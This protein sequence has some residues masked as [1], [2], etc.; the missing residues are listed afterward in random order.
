LGS[1]SP[2]NT[3][4]RILDAAEEL[5]AEQGTAAT[6]LRSLTRLAGVNLAA[7]HYHF[8]PKEALLDA[9]VDRRAGPINRARLLELARLE[10]TGG[11]DG[12]SMEELL[13][14]F[15]LPGLRSLRDLA[16][17][18]DTLTRLM[19]R[20]EGQ[21]AAEVEALYRRHF[22]EVSERFVAALCRALPHLPPRQ[23]AER[24]RFA[25]GILT[26]L[27]SGNLDLD[28]IPGH[29]PCTASDEERT[30]HALAFIVA[31]FRAPA[32]PEES[33]S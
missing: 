24:F 25:V 17:R 12:P 29:P 8:G 4:E 19:A 18:R 16:H 21:P 31:G 30:G 28:V 5:F 9:V 20:V 27:F 26:Q 14:A 22:G 2:E 6:S 7:V 33:P 32:A 15:I 10:Q 11:D 1:A 13:R 3:R 23:V